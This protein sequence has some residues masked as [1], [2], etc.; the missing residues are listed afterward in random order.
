M[1]A[2]NNAKPMAEGETALERLT[3]LPPARRAQ[4]LDAA[5]NAF[6][7]RGFSGASMNAILK[8]AEMSKGQV[9]YYVHDK[10]DLY[11]AVIARAL[12]GLTG[13]IDFA[14]ALGAHD[15]QAFWAALNAAFEQLAGLLIADPV[16][17]ALARTMY[18]GPQTEAALKAPLERLRAG[19][20]LLV[21]DG[22]A[23]GAIRADMPRRLIVD[24][25]FAAACALDRWFAENWDALAADEAQRINA[26]GLAMLRAMVAPAENLSRSA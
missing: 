11:S 8:Q 21:E 5:T 2:K 10:A 20:V 9:Y 14:A 6:A 12:D 22:Q 3:T 1:A 26:Q 24:M 17:A 19:A 23:L 7:E 18:E 25:L 15:A 13:R 4:L 16:L